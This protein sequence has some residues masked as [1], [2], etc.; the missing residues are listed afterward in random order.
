[1]GA[2]VKFQSKSLLLLKNWGVFTEKETPTVDDSLGSVTQEKWKSASWCQ[3]ENEPDPV[4]K[5]LLSWKPSETEK[6]GSSSEGQKASHC[7]GSLADP[8]PG[9]FHKLY[10]ETSCV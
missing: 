10:S 2:K 7:N 4:R 6:C 5:I 1:M 3:R 8:D 9:L